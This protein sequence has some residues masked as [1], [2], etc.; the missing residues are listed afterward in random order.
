MEIKTRDE[1][2]DHIRELWL[3]NET[4]ACWLH[5]IDYPMRI[6]SVVVSMAGIGGVWTAAEHRMK[7]YMRVLFEDT[8][9]YMT[10]QGYEVS[11]LFGIENFYH[12]YGYATCLSRYTCKVATRDAEAAGVLAQSFTTR[13]IEAADMPAVL[14][15][16]DER[17][18][19]RSG[20]I[21]RSID[22]FP[23]FRKG[24]WYDTSAE[25]QLWEDKTGAL[26]AYAVW[27]R[28][29]YDVKVS[30]IEAI[31][32]SLYPTLLY[33]LAEQAVAKRCETI[34]LHLPPDHSFAEYVKR[35][36]AEWKIEH[37]RFSDGM[38]RILN[39][40]PLFEKLLP[41]LARRLSESRLAGYTGKLSLKTDLGALGLRFEDGQVR[42][43][44]KVDAELSLALS[45]DR[46]TQL[47]MGYRSV[48]D[49]LNDPEV[50]M[51]GDARPLLDALFP[52]QNGFTWASDH[53]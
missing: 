48:R 39:L 20:S 46:L 14:A 51:Q 25:T 47:V 16:Y 4:K 18:A 13:P 1:G 33:A 12:K 11:L 34:E 15:L 23:A 6:G 41:E 35:Y 19:T 10:E 2:R 32:E 49:M 8:V 50:A 27:D 52:L 36:G 53:F 3:D 17:N 24:T 7:G 42:L 31:D 22:D 38:M 28:V 21:V 43:D 30:E 5:V 37:P 26:L 40:Q 44:E 9:R 45:Q 29:R